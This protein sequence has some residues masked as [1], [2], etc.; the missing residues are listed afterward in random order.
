M[1]CRRICVFTS[2]F[3]F[4]SLHVFGLPESFSCG[5][6]CSASLFLWTLYWPCTLLGCSSWTGLW[7]SSMGPWSFPVLPS[8]L[9][10]A[11]SGS[12]PCGC[13]VP[14]C[15]L[16][17]VGNIKFKMKIITRWT[18]FFFSTFVLLR[19]KWKPYKMAGAFGSIKLNVMQSN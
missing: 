14:D 7:L 1:C 13:T 4:F 9:S 15:W 3:F 16:L 12:N 18:S 6:L 11:D 10:L 5:S 2:M 8:A 19:I 17:E